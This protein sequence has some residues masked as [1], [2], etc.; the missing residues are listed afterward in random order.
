MRIILVALSFLICSPV[1][2]QFGGGGTDLSGVQSQIDSIVSG[3]PQPGDIV[4]LPDT[5][6]GAIGN[7]SRYMRQDAPRPTIS[8]RATVTTA[9]DGT[10]SVTWA[11]AFVSSTPAIFVTPLLAAAAQPVMCMVFTRSATAATG[12]CWQGA[13]NV[14]VILSLTI[15][16]API[17]F[18]TN[19]VMVIGLEP[20]Q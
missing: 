5:L 10:W 3:M 4:P 1:F 19:S 11:K 17:N 15:A 7:S 16:L 9:S 13:T 8:Q 14:N 20:S 2:A 12:K 6:N 18:V